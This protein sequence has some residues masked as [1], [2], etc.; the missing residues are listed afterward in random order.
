MDQKRTLCKRCRGDYKTAGFS[1]VSD[2]FQIIK[3][4]CDLC[5]RPGFDYIVRKAVVRKGTG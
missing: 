5:G 2:G 4:P 3:S 1:A